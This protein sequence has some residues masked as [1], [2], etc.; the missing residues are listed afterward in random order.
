MYNSAS[1]IDTPV[2]V[3]TAQPVSQEP[4]QFTSERLL[5]R[6]LLNSDFYAW[7]K[8]WQEEDNIANAGLEAMV[9]DNFARIWFNQTRKECAKVGILRCT[10]GAGT[11]IGDGGMYQFLNQWPEVVYLV[12]KKYPG[13]GFSTKSLKAL[14]D[15]W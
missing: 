2:K 6:P 8:L 14:M 11:F 10:N 15:V 1:T 13:E 9:H 4:P 3:K 12:E 5:M 7:H